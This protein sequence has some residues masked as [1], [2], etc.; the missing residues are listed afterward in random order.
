M[1]E[2]T[3][4][5]KEIRK[6]KDRTKKE[7]KIE[8]K[9]KKERKRIRKKETNKSPWACSSVVLEHIVGNVQYLLVFKVTGL[10]TFISFTPSFNYF[11][12]I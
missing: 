1:K 10:F 6:R 8:R 4:G 12:S 5:R 9:N 2:R 3:K 11:P 7:N